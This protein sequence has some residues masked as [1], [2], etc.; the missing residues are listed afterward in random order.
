MRLDELERGRPAR[1]AAIGGPLE[2]KLRE[3][4]FAEGDEVETVHFGPLARAPICVR[5]GR[6]M[7]ALRADEAAA[8][9]VE[10]NDAARREAAE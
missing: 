2:A 7:I 10:P 8:V 1:V 4:G 5:L 9:S 6:T 3:I